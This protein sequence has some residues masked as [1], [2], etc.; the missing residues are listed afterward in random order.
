M[1]GNTRQEQ[2][3]VDAEPVIAPIIS[4]YAPVH[5][6]VTLGAIY[7]GKGVAEFSAIDATTEATVSESPLT[8][9][10]L[11]MAFKDAYVPQNV[12]FGVSLRP[13]EWVMVAVDC[14]WF[15]WADY[16]DEVSEGDVVRSDADFETVDTWVPRVGF[17]FTPM[18][19]LT[20]RTGYYYEATPFENPGLGNTVVLDNSYHAISLGAAHTADY[21]PFM[22]HPVNVGA[23]YFYHHMIERTVEND[24]DVEFESSGGIQGVVGT[25]SLAF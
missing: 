14:T 25:L 16:D 12:A 4:L 10:N 22:K 18:S 2:I 1:A 17:E 11:M 7:R 23:T 21:I 9:L 20:L 8:T 24:A 13:A 6:M 3:Q 5:P 15:N 19:Y